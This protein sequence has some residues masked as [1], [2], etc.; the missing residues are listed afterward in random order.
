MFGLSG[1][2]SFESICFLI[3]ST[4][5][6]SA[7]GRLEATL[8]QFGQ[9]FKWF[10]DNLKPLLLLSLANEELL[11]ESCLNDQTVFDGSP[12]TIRY[13]TSNG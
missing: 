12:A 2:F 9:P 8:K 3:A 6:L 4:L 7:N 10:S 13:N 5:S 1:R 11:S